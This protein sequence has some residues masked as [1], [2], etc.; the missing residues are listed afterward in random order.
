MKILTILGA[1]PQFIKA[2]AVSRIFYNS[3]NVSEVIVHTGQHF[4]KNM[5]EVFFDQLEIPKPHYNLKISGLSHGA[6][7]AR[8]LENIE[9]LILKE[10][11]TSVLVYGDTNST[12]AGALAASKL[13]TPIIHVEAG[14]RSFNACMPEEVNRILTDRLSSYLFCPTAVAVDNLHAEGYPFNDSSNKLQVIEN[15]GDVMFDAMNFY[16]EKSLKTV[17]LRSLGIEGRG[18]V[19]CTIHRQENTENISKLC[20]IL[21]ALVEIAKNKEVILP[22]HPRTAAKLKNLDFDT[23]DIKILAPLP[24]LEMQ[25]L[26][27]DASCVLTDS[28]GMQKEAYFH[29]VPCV[30]L[31]N[32]TEWTETVSSGWNKLVGDNIDKIVEASTSQAIPVRPI[33][34]FYGSGS[35]SVKILETLGIS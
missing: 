23:K 9:G 14:L 8:M 30:T 26:I 27:M 24:Y 6:M 10:Q 5:S 20:N 17:D 33:E 4:D 2:A 1:R 25:R 31:R 19:V 34:P 28:G 11:P 15:V 3:S 7:T 35:A 16:R 29:E 12:L 13:N 22:V 21:T 18:Y 32:E